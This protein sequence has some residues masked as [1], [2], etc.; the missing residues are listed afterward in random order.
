M[1]H[2]KNCQLGDNW[3]DCPACIENGEQNMAETPQTHPE[4]NREIVSLLR[5]SGEPFQL[6]AAA[7]I[8]ELERERDEARGGTYETKCKTCGV[9]QWTKYDG[10]SVVCGK[11]T[12]R[13]FEAERD[14]LAE[15]CEGAIAAIIEQIEIMFWTSFDGNEQVPATSES[16]KK[17]VSPRFGDTFGRLESALASARKALGKEQDGQ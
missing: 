7:R 15:H 12:C 14:S 11:C 2:I 10:T 9:R 1:N 3:K 16:L 6:Y 5:I 8:E 17:D 13:E 4:M